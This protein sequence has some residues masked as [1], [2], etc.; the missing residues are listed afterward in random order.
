MKLIPSRL[1][2]PL[3]SLALG[4]VLFFVFVFYMSQHAAP[5]QT[6]SAFPPDVTLNPDALIAKSA[7]IYDPTDGRVL[8][9]KDDNTS[10]PLA[11][12][13]KLM[14]AQAILSTESTNQYITI[15]PQDISYDGYWGFKVGDVVKL[16]DLL[17]F[18]LVASSNDAMAAAATSLG[19]NYLDEMNQDA[20]E[21]GLSHTYFLNPTGLDLTASTSGAYGSAG[22]VALL[23][24]SFL[25][26]YPQY[27]ELSTEPTV[28]IPDGDRTISAKATEVPIQNIPGFIG[29]KTGYTDLA[30]GNV[31]VAYDIEI[32][33]PLIAVV[34][35]STEKGRFTDIETLIDASR[36]A[37]ASE[38]TL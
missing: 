22:D 15:T 16:Q 9:D 19:G 34:L 24:A 4:S 10:R 12:I 38:T 11:S 32:G 20:G 21:L 2:I 13:T 31:V 5:A 23:A 18:G 7:I 25:R 3:C 35:G 1:F 17:R 6:A 29:A 30:G 28:S 37:A 36:A 27:F 14:T 26:K 8:Y 33:H